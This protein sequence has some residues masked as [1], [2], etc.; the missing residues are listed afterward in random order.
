MESEG[1][2]AV[3]AQHDIIFISVQKWKTTHIII[4]PVTDQIKPIAKEDLPLELWGNAVDYLLLLMYVCPVTHFVLENDNLK[5]IF[6][7]VFG[8]SLLHVSTSIRRK[9]KQLELTNH[10]SYGLHKVSL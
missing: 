5:H 4:T 7:P 1:L 6:V 2:E 3:A 10:S 9:H 8:T